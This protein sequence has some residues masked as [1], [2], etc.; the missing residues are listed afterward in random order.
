MTEKEAERCF[1]LGG[2]VIYQNHLCAIVGE[3]RIKHVFE[4]ERLT[5][6][7]HVFD[8]KAT[9]LKAEN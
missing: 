2:S 3:N 7:Q 5:D 1:L 4:L 8:I 9:E 6:G